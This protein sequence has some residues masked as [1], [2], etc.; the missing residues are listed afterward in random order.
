MADPLV[1]AGGPCCQN[2]EPMADY[3]D[4]MITGDGEPVLP[5]VCQLWLEL[6]GRCR[7]DDGSFAAG[8]AGRRERA[9]S[10]AEIARAI[11]SAYVPRFYQPEYA[12]GRIAAHDTLEGLRRQ[13]DCAG[14][15]ADVL[16]RLTHPQT[17]DNVRRYFEHN[18]A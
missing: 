15:L 5:T 10:L 14:P 11:D 9:E 3:F 13:T 4:V 12:D 7:R 8:D 6:K 18:P 16:A 1:V 2:P 17:L